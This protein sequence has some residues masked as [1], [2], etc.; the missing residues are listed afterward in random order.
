[1]MI[2]DKYEYIKFSNKVY[3]FLFKPFDKI[4]FPVVNKDELIE[5]RKKNSIPLNK[6]ANVADIYNPEWG[7][8][9]KNI[10]PIFGMEPHTFHRKVWEFTHILFVLKKLGYLHPDNE[11]LS[12]AA[13]REQILYYLAYKI[14]KIIGIDL[15]EGNFLGGEDESD[16]PVNP[17][18]YAPFKYPKA[19]L[20][21]MK[22]DALNLKFKDDRFDFVF[23]ASSIEHFGSENEIKKSIN[24]MFRVL[25]PGGLCVITSEIRLNKLARDIPHT[26]LF[27]LN[28]LIKYFIESGFEMVEEKVDTRIEDDSINNWIKLPQ[29]VFK[30]PHVILRFFRSVFTSVALSFKKPGDNV[31]K[32]DW[33]ANEVFRHFS[34]KSSLIVEIKNNTVK[35]NEGIELSIT[36][37]NKSNFDWFVNGMSHRIAIGV[38]LLDM[39]GNIIDDGFD[40]ITIPENI[41]TGKRF[42]FSTVFKPS[43]LKRGNF[44]LFFDLKREYVTWFSEKGESPCV[45]EIS[46]I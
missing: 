1:M 9:L 3:N 24:E 13:G 5:E 12:I 20:E 14:K 46:V 15:Y 42:S 16:V 8:M 4:L 36:I 18:K 44:K 43:K 6:I 25:K 39:K 41:K 11:G 22:M 27:V 34:Y 21:L 17:E 45:L 37:E 35:I 19:N 32:G 2:K 23:S 31:K 30:T 33:K 26:R 29:E 40:E 10:K 7:E 28:N 38:K